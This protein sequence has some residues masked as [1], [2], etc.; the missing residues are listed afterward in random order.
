M[1]TNNHSQ[2]KHQKHA[3]PRKKRTKFI[4]P[5]SLSAL[6]VILLILLVFLWQRNTVPEMA[7]TP[8]HVSESFSAD[9]PPTPT[10][11]LVSDE[12]SDEPEPTP[13][14]TPAPV[15]I[16]IDFQYYRSRNSDMIAWI[17][18]D[19]TDIDYPVLYDSSTD[20]Y[21]LDHTMWGEYSAAGSIFIE[22]DYNYSDFQ[23][24]NTVL[25]GH[26]M[27]SGAM[28]AQ[29]HRFKDESFFEENRYITI[30]TPDSK[31]T[32]EIFAAYRTDNLHL[33]ANF[34]IGSAD[35]RSDYIDHIYS[36]SSSVF[37]SDITVTESDKIITLST[38]VGIS[39]QRFLVQGV[40]ISDEPGVY[41]TSE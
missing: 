30:Y 14:P 29:L 37:D 34:D 4:L 33:L 39:T 35:D 13:E 25:Y 8:V 7:A 32:Y 12:P 20:F 10:P 9:L 19:G 40:L 27:A 1:K 24:F 22:E 17:F 28:F 21:Y 18:V 15:D 36:H 16:P 23:D 5:V 2:H 38:C 6:A 26:N 31:L 11:E 3:A 41:N